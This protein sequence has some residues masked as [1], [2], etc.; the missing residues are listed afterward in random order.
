MTATTTDPLQS[1]LL[2]YLSD[3]RTQLQTW[4]TTGALIN[5]AQQ[6]LVLEQVPKGLKDLNG[7]L[8]AG[9]WSDLPKVEILSGSS[10]GGAIGAWASSTSTIYLNSDWL[11]T[12]NKAQISAVLTEEF[13]HYLDSK[14]NAVDTQGDEGELFSRI[15]SGE[16][17]GKTGHE[18]IRTE[19]DT[20]WLTLQNGR[21][22]KAE[23]ATITG[24]EGNDNITGTNSADTINGRGGND[25]IDGRAGSDA[26]LGG[27]GNDTIRGGDGNDQIKGESGVDNLYGDNGDDTFLSLNADNAYGGSGNDKFYGGA[28]VGLSLIHI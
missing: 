19:D 11:S 20:V 27:D 28:P 12:A 25:T 16:E 22:I 7:R 13:G 5:A 23:A 8:V 15:L 18:S 2:G 9:D 17:L 6:A 14:F 10:M 4:A 24:G 1:L 26:I 21:T 3:W